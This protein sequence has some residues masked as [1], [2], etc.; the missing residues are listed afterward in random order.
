MNEIDVKVGKISIA[1]QYLLSES[2]NLTAKNTELF[3]CK[4][5][6]QG[7]LK[8]WKEAVACLKL[9]SSKS[10]QEIR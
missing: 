2:D 7:D 9:E 5:E 4:K 10:E 1:N 6:Y 3:S 8:K